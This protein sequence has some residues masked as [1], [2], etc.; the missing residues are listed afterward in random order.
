MME[1]DHAWPLKSEVYLAGGAVGPVKN[2]IWEF[3]TRHTDE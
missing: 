3:F 1:A 2:A